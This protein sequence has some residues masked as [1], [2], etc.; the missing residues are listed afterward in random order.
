MSTPLEKPPGPIDL[1]AYALQRTR[2]RAIA[3]PYP[4]GTDDDPPLSPYAPKRARER[5]GTGQEFRPAIDL[6]APDIC[7]GDA[8]DGGEDAPK[9]A[10]E[11]DAAKFSV[12]PES[13][14]PL[15]PAP[16]PDGGRHVTPAA[17]R[18][19]ASASE[20][21][22]ERLEASLRWLQRQEAATR[23]AR[24]NQPPPRRT[25]TLLDARDR[26]LSGERFVERFGSPISLEPERLAPPPGP[27]R[28]LRAPLAILVASIF[29]AS[30]IYYFLVAGSGPSSVRGPA[31]QMASFDSRAATPPPTPSAQPRH[32]PV[33]ARGDDPAASPQSEPFSQ[34]T[35]PPPPARSSEGETL[36]MLQPGAP[37]AQAPF[38]AEAVRPLDPGEIELLMQQGEQFIAAG[39]LVTAR[40][41]FQ[42]AAEAHDANAALA[43]AATYD[44]TVLSKLGVVGMS[45][46]L[47]KARTWY[48]KAESLGS[49]D[50]ARR[51][52]ALANR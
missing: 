33:L 10:F 49:A 23:L 7:P 8:P 29:A 36:A 4:S 6:E 2:A 50:A 40:T 14:V 20:Y 35:A 16:E 46:D 3:E 43:L 38:P 24:A 31:P 5:G 39:D 41:V 37:S 11:R 13:A 17:E 22:L 25:S 18:S 30:A 47:E 44:P 42:R 15:Q 21:D 45:A 27:G 19:D 51:L 26:R 48:Q 52:R 34:P 12:D 32:P 28:N 9:L 1:S